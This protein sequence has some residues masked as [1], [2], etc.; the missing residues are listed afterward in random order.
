MSLTGLLTSKGGIT[1]TGN[2]STETMSLTDKLSSKGIS[3][4]GDISNNGKIT[5]DTLIVN[6]KNVEQTLSNLDSQLADTKSD[7]LQ[8]IQQVSAGLNVIGSVAGKFLT[9]DHNYFGNFF[10]HLVT[11]GSYILNSFGEGFGDTYHL[12]L[13]ENF[14]YILYNEGGF[15]RDFLVFRVTKQYN[16]GII[17]TLTF[18]VNE[19][20]T[21][22]LKSPN[23]D[24]YNFVYVVDRLD[25][26]VGNN[27]SGGYVVKISGSGSDIQR[28][29]V[30][31]TG[32][33][34]INSADLT[35][36]PYGTNSTIPQL[37]KFLH[38]EIKLIR[39]NVTITNSS[40]QVLTFE[41][42]YVSLI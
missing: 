17:E 3:N 21:N 29:L 41:P 8:E 18:T 12:L 23:N 15:N 4:E 10:P 33:Q 35:V 16:E 36:G 26:R 27:K 20:F 5:T 31:F 37:L 39:E 38:D 24:K 30:Q 40:N 22:Q 2:I 14:N 28:D 6:G 19:D 42:K 11:N 9:S 7:L 34:S 1:N 25:D 32:L 13:Q